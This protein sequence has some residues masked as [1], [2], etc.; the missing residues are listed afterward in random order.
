M[1]ESTSI[2]LQPEYVEHFNVMVLNV[3]PSVAKIGVLI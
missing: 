3:M 1:T 2:V